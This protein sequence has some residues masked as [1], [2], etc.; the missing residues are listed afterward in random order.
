MVGHSGQ[1]IA[2]LFE[3]QSVP[4]GQAVLALDGGRDGAIEIG[5]GEDE[6]DLRPFEAGAFAKSLVG[7]DG[8]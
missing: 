1:L 4:L 5:V 6:D 8:G 7:L 3:L 2:G